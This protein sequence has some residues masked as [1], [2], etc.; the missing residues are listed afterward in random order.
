V[1]TASASWYRNAAAG[2]IQLPVAEFYSS[3]A[4]PPGWPLPREV[5]DALGL[6]K[7]FLWSSVGDLEESGI[8]L[9][10][11]A[12]LRRGV[13]M[14]ASYSLQTDPGVTPAAPMTGAAVP[15][16][17]PPRHRA[18]A[19][20]QADRGRFVGS[21]ALSYTGRAFWTDVLA[22]QGWTPSFWLLDASAG[23]RFRDGRLTWLV[24][25]TNL[26]DRR[27]QHHIFGDVIRRRVTT[28]L[29]ISLED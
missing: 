13:S 17:R 16:N 10:L 27:V 14:S 23:V 20:L 1:T 24:K 11:D 12:P 5:V 7:T 8:E 2:L 9:A 4:P 29:R 28:E 22:F 6:P 26:A 15:V 25:G 19:R 21:A 3:A 18:N